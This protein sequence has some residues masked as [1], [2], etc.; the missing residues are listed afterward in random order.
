MNELNSHMYRF[1]FK[2]LLDYIG[3]LII[4]IIVSPILVISIIGLYIFNKRQVFFK[5][6]RPGKN[7]KIFSILKFKTMTDDRD[8]DGNLLPDQ[9]RMTKIGQFI[10]STSMDEL[11]Q[12]I[13]ILKGE[14]S[15]IGPRPLLPE[16]LSLYSEEQNKRHLMK[17]GITG[18]AQVNGR[19]A[20]S[21]TRKLEL[22]VWYINHVSFIVD[23]MIILK[24]IQKVIVK[25]GISQEGHVTIEPFNG[26]N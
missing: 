18:W 10:R 24:T 14:M 11:P 21:W 15:F 8:A 16:Y 20:I 19:N 1:F 23:V 6:E 3:S 25:E 5:Q 9:Y 7:G 13:N 2:S 22:D 12:L 26:K 4:L 17:P